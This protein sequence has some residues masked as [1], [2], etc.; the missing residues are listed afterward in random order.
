[1]AT[2][3]VLAAGSGERLGG[4][5]AKGFRRIGGIHGPTLLEL[6]VL[7]AAA[8]ERIDAVVVT[9]PPGRESEGERLAAAAAGAVETRVVAGGDTR[10]TSVRSALD[11]VG[12]E[13]E[14]VAVHD[15][16]RCLAPPRLFDAVV[17]ALEDHASIAGAIPVVS[18][19]D[20]IKRVRDGVVV[21]TIDRDELAAVQTPQAFRIEVL[22]RAHAAA[23]VAGLLGT[24]DAMLVE[25]LGERVVTVPGESGNFKIT[26]A[27]DLERAAMTVRGGVDG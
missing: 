26:T 3:I 23:E 20:T 21:E 7:A 27:E 19:A 18:V 4:G 11:I 24:D 5:D 1:M 15:A 16:A 8:A 6:A 12:S 25:R 13:A 2:A 9:V 10:Q 22:R 14:I 17:V